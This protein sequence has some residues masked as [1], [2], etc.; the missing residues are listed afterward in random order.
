LFGE[1]H[2]L[3]LADDAPKKP[4]RDN[5][6]DS[7]GFLGK[8]GQHDMA[9][10]FISGHGENDD[11]GN[12]FFL[13]SDAALQDDGSLRASRAVSWRD[14]KSVVDEL[15]T[16]KLVLLDTCHSEGVSG[17]RAEKLRGLRVGDTNK[18][19][20]ELQDFGAVVFTSSRGGEFSRESSEWG[21]GAFTY[22]LLNGLRGEAGL[23]Q[24]EV[25][26]MK[27]LDAYVS[28]KV[29]ELTGGT[30]HPITFTP[31]GYLDFPVAKRK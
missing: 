17:K 31:E 9:L 4:T 27:E 12:Y 1:V 7:L 29:P 11:R 15:P 24:E 6:V 22:A 23:R 19:V 8:V 5:I 2:T 13:P 28:R 14:L 26:T 3:I 10:L 18:L 21:H 30:Q 25:I 20:K 16:R